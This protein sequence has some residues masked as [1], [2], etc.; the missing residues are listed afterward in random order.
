MEGDRACVGVNGGGNSFEVK[1]RGDRVEVKNGSGRVEV[2]ER[3]PQLDRASTPACRG[4][5][6][7][8]AVWVSPPGK[9]ARVALPRDDY[10]EQSSV[11]PLGCSIRPLL[12]DPE[13]TRENLGQP[14]ATDVAASRPWDPLSTTAVEA[15]SEVLRLSEPAGLVHQ[16]HQ[17]T[18]S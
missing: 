16:V 4:Q 8:F 3:R 9:N 18:L 11:L 5:S 7:V 2:R 15:G 6:Q 17:S 10:L 12:L 1:D 14:P 13:G